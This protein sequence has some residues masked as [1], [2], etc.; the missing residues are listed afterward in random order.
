M[1]G[2]LLD[3]QREVT[4]SPVMGRDLGMVAEKDGR[5]GTEMW[6]AGHVENKT[7]AQVMGEER[8]WSQRFVECAG[9]TG[10]KA[11]GGHVWCDSGGSKWW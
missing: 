2:G 5:P 6:S 8:A 10:K 3:W 7:V 9:E 11:A 4:G 1:G